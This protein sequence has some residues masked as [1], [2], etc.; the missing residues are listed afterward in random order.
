MSDWEHVVVL[1]ADALRADHLS[2][3]NYQR[4]TSPVLDDLA[5]ES[6]RFTNAYSASSHTRKAVPALPTG[7]YPDSAVDED[8]RLASET[9][10]TTLSERGFATGG[11][12]SNPFVSRAY[13]FDRGFDTFRAPPSESAYFAASASPTLQ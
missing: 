6:L 1:S 8:Y 5:A 13:G 2:C 10:A 7:E 9:V 11:F 4:E 3:Y 12:H